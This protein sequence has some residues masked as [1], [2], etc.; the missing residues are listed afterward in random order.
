MSAMRQSIIDKAFP[1]FV[2]QFMRENFVGKEY[3]TWAVDALK[4]VNIDVTT[5]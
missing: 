3:P 1:E 5:S 2:R 4:A